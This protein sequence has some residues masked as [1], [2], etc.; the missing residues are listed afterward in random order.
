MTEP[1]EFA[2]FL[3]ASS[4]E[5]EDLRKALLDGACKDDPDLKE[6]I[7][8]MFAV[9]GDAS[10][11]FEARSPRASEPE[12][13]AGKDQVDTRIGPYRIIDRLGEGGYGVVYLAEQEEPVRRKVAL[14]IIR[15]GMDT[16]RVIARF[17]AERQSLAM[18]DHPNIARVLDAGATRSGRM[19]FVMELVDGDAITDFC[20]QHRFGIRKRLEVFVQVCQAIQHAH[21]KGVIHRD[22]KPNNILVRMQDDR[23]VPTVIDFGVAKAGT[24]G[25]GHDHSFTGPDQFVGTPAYLSPEV[26][27][28]SSDVDTRCDIHGL[29]LV[30]F[31]LI[32][33][34][35][36]LGRER[37]KK[38]SVD[39]IRRII[40]EEDPPSPSG[41]LA[42]LDPDE[43]VRR[44]EL[45]GISGPKL[46]HRVKG[47]LDWIV[48]KALDRERNRRYE[49]ALGLARDVERHLNKEAVLA[50]PPNTYYRLSRLFRR[51]RAAFLSGAAVFLALAAGFWTSTVLFIREKDARNEQERLRNEAEAARANEMELRQ[52]SEF[53]ERISHAAVLVSHD[54]LE[55]ADQLLQSVPFGQVPASLEASEAYLRLGEWHLLAGQWQKATDYFANVALVLPKVDPSDSYDISIFV[56]PAAALLVKSNDLERYE[57]IR[58]RTIERFV[59]TASP[60]VAEQVLKT[61]LLTPPD[62]GTLEAMR[63]LATLLETALK[64]GHPE[65]DS[66]NPND[67]WRNFRTSWCS[68]ALALYRYREGDM[69]GAA[70]WTNYALPIAGGHIPR[71]TDLRCLRAMIAF[72]GGSPREARF[73]L[74]DAQRALEDHAAKPFELGG[75]AD[76]WYDWVIARILYE[77]ARTLVPE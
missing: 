39:E 29:G 13:E 1:Y 20:D 68:F 77:E 31:E 43:L 56:I 69:E 65:L 72:R 30:L 5:E 44:A 18:M 59:N 33:G 19:Y 6:R 74:E 49:S 38:L 62:S 48:G 12:T 11:F 21:Q 8:R 27:A 58:Q 34:Q 52:R 40:C 16:E 32:T 3:A 35:P 36:P 57:V 23:P 51:H 75:V 42:S 66:G 24:D 60:V 63:P 41:S 22:I 61:T 46:V 70:Y 71:E 10:H 26:A 55:E 25:N 37:T 4:L 50:S 2:L 53:R 15:P 54:D 9:Q 7:E 73:L 28:G 47:D 64:E 67:W 14:K 17:E 45:R 76:F